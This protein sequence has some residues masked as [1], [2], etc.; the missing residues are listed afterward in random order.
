MEINRRERRRGE[1]ERPTNDVPV[2]RPSIFCF[3]FFLLFL[4]FGASVTELVVDGLF[5][6]RHRRFSSN[7]PVPQTTTAT[8]LYSNSNENHA[9]AIQRFP[10]STCPR[11][12][13]SPVSLYWLPGSST[14]F[15]FGR[16]YPGCG[17]SRFHPKQNKSPENTSKEKARRKT[18]IVE[19]Q[20]DRSPSTNDSL[21]LLKT[22]R[23]PSSRVFSFSLL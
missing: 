22:T 6:V 16:V 5:V 23:R 3:F 18:T 7:R 2:S 17:I 13:I 11:S 15:S 9:P 19:I 8:L 4:V 20:R 12:T 10:S 21:L 14:Y 1:S